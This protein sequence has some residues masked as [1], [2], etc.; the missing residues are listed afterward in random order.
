MEPDPADGRDVPALDAFRGSEPAGGG[1]R[2]VLL[3][4]DEPGAADLA[5]THV[6]R[7]VDGVETVTRTSPADALAVVREQRVDCVVSDYNMPESDGLELLEDVRTVDPGLPFVLFTGRGSEEIASEAISAGVTDY[8]QKGVGRDRFEMLANSVENALDRRRVER[9]LR[10]VNA[11]VTAIHE[12]ASDVAAAEDAE[13]VL[14]RLVSAAERILS[15]DRCV[16]V[17]RH[18]D[19]LIPAARSENVSEDEVRTFDVGEGVVGATVAEE[20]TIVVDNLSVDPSDP[21]ELEDPNDPGRETAGGGTEAASAPADD[22]RRAEELADPVGDD[23]RSAISVPIGSYGAFQAVSD[24]YAAFDQSDVEFAELLAAHAA[25]ALEQIETENTLRTERDRVEALFDDLPLPVARAVSSPGDAPK[26]DAVNDAFEAVFGLAGPDL[27]YGAIREGI[28]PAGSE[29]V[30]P[31]P[32]IDAAEPLQREVERETTDGR[33]NFILN[34]LPVEQPNETIVYALYADIDEQKRVARTLRRLHE[35]TREMLRGEDREE[36]ASIA[37]RA[38][39]DILEFPSSGVRLYDPDTNTLLPTA[40]SREATDALGERPAYGPG[41]GR[42]WEAFETG[43]LVVVDDLDEVETAI[44]YGEHRSLLIVPLGDHGIMP[45]GSREPGVFDDT[46]VQLARVLGANVTVAL[47]HAQRTAQLRE[48]D[49]ELQREIDRLEK[50]A[51]LVSHDLRNPLNVAA[52]RLALAQGKVDDEGAR[53]ELEAVAAAHDRM[54]ELIEDLLAL[55]RHGQTV[56]E[57]EPLSL[58]EAAAKAWQTVDTGDAVLRRPDDSLTV[59]ADPERLRTLLENLFTNSVEHGATAAAGA[60]AA[61]HI[62]VT[63]GPLPDGFY[64]DDDGPGFEMDPE[65]AVE[66][67]ISS[68]PSGTGFGLAIVREIAAAHGWTLAVTDDE[69]VRFAFRTDG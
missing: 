57:P 12:F 43:E 41:S 7:L 38:A 32:V 29:D 47:D 14:T 56:D 39:I 4:D 21:E 35:T 30:D 3:V 51:G 27:D 58:S 61:D 63:V 54:E 19:K 48:R 62:T 2:R 8:L 5:A 67:G 6:E 34:V 1:P 18:G 20:R 15:F 52:G 16:S 40:I 9:D 25:D 36:I 26:L 69:G 64:V 45:L 10:G 50:F 65:E 55:A 49:A 33:R 17:R 53:E 31:L 68:D 44:G 59:E 23:I 46:A 11:K 22:Q 13:D 24:G 66:Y 28:V 60:G 42:L 37:T